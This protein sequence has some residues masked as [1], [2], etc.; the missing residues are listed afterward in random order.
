[1]FSNNQ[2]LYNWVE[3]I[4]ED[5]NAMEESDWAED[6]RS[7]MHSGATGGEVLG[8]LRLILIKFENTKIPRRIKKTAEVKNALKDLDRSLGPRPKKQ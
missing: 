8:A 2:E 4:I 7:A 5:L 1:M 3:L 6:F